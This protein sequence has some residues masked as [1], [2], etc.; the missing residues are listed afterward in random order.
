MTRKRFDSH[1]TEFGLWLRKQRNIDSSLGYIATNI[2]YV[3]RNYK[4]GDWML[5][6][7]KRYMTKVKR[8]QQEIFNLLT[9]CSKHHPKFHGFHILQ[10]ENTS[11]EDGE[12][13]LDGRKI[14]KEE[15]INFLQFSEKITP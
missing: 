1:S 8:W 2:D 3:W 15:L 11:P 6:E 5:I 12:I 14:T 13:F 10:F 4:T 9:W 7:E